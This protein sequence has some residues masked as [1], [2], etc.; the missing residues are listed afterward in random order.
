M[1]LL[2]VV[3]KKNDNKNKLFP[4]IGVNVGYSLKK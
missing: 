2:I 1:L 4:Q 3:R